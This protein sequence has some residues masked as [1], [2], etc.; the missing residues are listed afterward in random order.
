MTDL[1][2]PKEDCKIAIR[3]ISQSQYK[4]QNPTKMGA[5]T[6]TG[7][8]TLTIYVT[9]L[10]LRLIVGS[11]FKPKKLTDDKIQWKLASMLIMSRYV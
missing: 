11:P 2:L 6:N 4:A 3:T 9:G 8:M 7:L 10:H 5:T 1:N